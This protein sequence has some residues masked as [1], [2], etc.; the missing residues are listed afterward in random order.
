MRL[1]LLLAATLSA[2]LYGIPFIFNF[3]LP[4]RGGWIIGFLVSQIAVSLVLGF[5]TNTYQFA[6]S[7]FL[8]AATI[9]ALLFWLTRSAPTAMLLGGAVL[10]LPAGYYLRR[11]H[12]NMGD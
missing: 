4:E 9:E 3:A 12:F 6:A 2:V 11:F 1:R 7:V 5:A 10:G 8:I